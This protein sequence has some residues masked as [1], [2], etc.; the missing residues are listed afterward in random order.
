MRS[1]LWAPI[2]YRGQVAGDLYLSN[3]QG[4]AEFSEEDQRIVEMLASR[5]GGAIETARLYAAEGRAHAWLQAVVDQMP[6][7]IVLMDA[8]GRITV[9]NQALRVIYERR[10]AG[11]RFGNL[12]TIDLRRK[13]VRRAGA[14]RHADRQGHGGPGDHLGRG[15]HRSA[16]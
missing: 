10:A 13:S 16:N 9:E 4:G 1:F 2:R 7:G 14:G 11:D 8:E 15:I 5:A 3:K 12:M 6:E